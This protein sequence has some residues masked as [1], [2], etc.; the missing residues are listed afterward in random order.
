MDVNSIINDYPDITTAHISSVPENQPPQPVNNAE[1]AVQANP[2]EYIGNN[3][4][5]TA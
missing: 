5:I 1:T 2:D 4:D 3:V